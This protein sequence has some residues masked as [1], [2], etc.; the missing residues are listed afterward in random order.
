MIS[1]DSKQAGTDRV[2]LEQL[3][4]PHCR[5]EAREHAVHQPRK[6]Q[7]AHGLP[8]SLSGLELSG[9]TLGIEAGLLNSEND[10]SAIRTNDFR[11]SEC[12]SKK[13]QFQKFRAFGGL[14]Q[15]RDRR[16]TEQMYALVNLR[17][18]REL[19]NI[20]L[21]YHGAAHVRGR[22][23]RNLELQALPV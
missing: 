3:S 9:Q 14:P 23:C 18:N 5:I 1:N 13:G 16:L 22:L 15:H 11:V 19:D 20:Q 12:A 4:V 21:K 2:H 10:A 7:G 17:K 6:L 8:P